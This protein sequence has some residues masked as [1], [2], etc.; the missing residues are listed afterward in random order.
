MPTQVWVLWVGCPWD[1]RGDRAPAVSWRSQGEERVR[2]QRP[3]RGQT[4]IVGT[5]V[6]AGRS[7]PWLALGYVT[8]HNGRVQEDLLKYSFELSTDPTLVA[9]WLVG[10]SGAS[11]D[12]GSTGRGAHF[13]MPP[14]PPAPQDQHLGGDSAWFQLLELLWPWGHLVA[15][16][17][18]ACHLP[19]REASWLLQHW[20]LFFSI[21][22]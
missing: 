10:G 18:K 14:C 7:L 16:I 12:T 5:H 21:T 1:I 2:T 20:E 9:A 17:P 13:D 22:M 8:P 19:P 15:T 6:A 3:T 4:A 11:R